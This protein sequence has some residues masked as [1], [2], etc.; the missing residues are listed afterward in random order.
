MESAIAFVG[1]VER[2]RVENPNL[3]MVWN[4]FIRIEFMDAIQ[5]L[6]SNGLIKLGY[7]ASNALFGG[8]GF[9]S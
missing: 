7:L 4:S 5:W 2:E 3:G 6:L 1:L 8:K 9:L